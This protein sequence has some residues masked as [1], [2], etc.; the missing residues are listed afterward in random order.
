M[1]DTREKDNDKGQ[2]MLDDKN[3]DEWYDML[4]RGLLRNNDVYSWLCASPSVEPNF[5]TEAYEHFERIVDGEAVPTVI[6]KWRG[7]SGKIKWRNLLQLNED[8]RERW[9]V[10]MSEIVVNVSRHVRPD[11][12]D[13]IN[14]QKSIRTEWQLG[15]SE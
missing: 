6:A 5:E 4:T 2:P 8:R 11:L 13:R 7:E 12:W 1:E 3:Y 14:S 9:P 15:P 10:L